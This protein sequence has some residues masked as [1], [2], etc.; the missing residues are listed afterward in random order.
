M[1]Q[2]IPSL[3]PGGNFL[4]PG[5]DPVTLFHTPPCSSPSASGHLGEPGASELISHPMP[6]APL[7]CQTSQPVLNTPPFLSPAPRLLTGDSVL[8]T[9]YW[10]SPLRRTTPTAPAHSGTS[11]LPGPLPLPSAPTLGQPLPS[12]SAVPQV[13]TSLPHEGP[14]LTLFLSPEGTGTQRDVTTFQGVSGFGQGCSWGNPR[15]RVRAPRETTSRPVL[16]PALSISLFL[17]L[18]PTMH[19]PLTAAV[20]NKLLF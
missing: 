2:C 18:S 10:L 20:W 11:P 16:S 19:T 3:D 8:V 13:R 12:A 14:N 4:P 1:L 5:L 15:S 7:L 9:C 17:P 6:Q